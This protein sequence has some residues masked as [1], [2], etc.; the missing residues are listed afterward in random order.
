MQ[1]QGAHLVCGVDKAIL[2]W[3]AYAPRVLAIAPSRIPLID[4][5]DN[6]RPALQK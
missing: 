5:N 1:Y 2:I 3:G 4:S 6:D